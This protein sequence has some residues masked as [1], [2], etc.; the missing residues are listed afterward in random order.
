MD[1]P[2]YHQSNFVLF[3]QVQKKII[4]FLLLLTIFISFKKTT[5]FH[6]EDAKST[7]L[8]KSRHVCAWECLMLSTSFYDFYLFTKTLV[9]VCVCVYVCLMRS[10]KRCSVIAWMCARI[11]SCTHACVHWSTFHSRD[12]CLLLPWWGHRV[13]ISSPPRLSNMSK[14]GF[15]CR[16]LF[17]VI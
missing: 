10:F 6:R 4:I 9:L 15:S 11:C 8:V 3:L 13:H 1:T 17:N 14:M 16:I 7:H 5:F 12:I 2:S